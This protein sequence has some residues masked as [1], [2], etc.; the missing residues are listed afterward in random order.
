MDAFTA[1]NGLDI[2]VANA[3]IT[4]FKSFLEVE[5][6]EFARLMQVN[7]QGTYFAVQ[8]AAKIMIQNAIRGRIVLMSSVCGYQAHRHLSAYAMTKAGIMQLAR[9]LSE[10]LGDYHRNN[11][12]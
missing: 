5:V 1:E 2:F 7:M 4:V 9:S 3:G 10:E 6:A 12:V 11:F 8:S